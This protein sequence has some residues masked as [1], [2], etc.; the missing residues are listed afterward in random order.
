MIFPTENVPDEPDVSE[1]ISPLA[2]MIEEPT[3]PESTTAETEE[4][5]V[6]NSENTEEN[7]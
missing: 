1:E 4:T 7:K 3:E 5:A 2:G 6:E